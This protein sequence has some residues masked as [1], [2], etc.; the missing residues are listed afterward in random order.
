MRR[1][2][3][4]HV[5]DNVMRAARRQHPELFEPVGIAMADIKKGEEGPVQLVGNGAPGWKPARKSGKRKFNNIKTSDPETGLTFDSKLEHKVWLALVEKYG[6]RNVARQ[7]SFLLR[8]GRRIRPDFVVFVTDAHGR[9][10][11][12]RVIDAKGGPPTEVWSYKASDL[13]ADL[14]M[15]IEI[16][17]KPSEV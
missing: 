4:R 12:E 13:K 3:S 6:R 16:I 15:D 9:R 2:R 7:V 11:I 17:R 8:N 10:V 5:P 1:S 14:D